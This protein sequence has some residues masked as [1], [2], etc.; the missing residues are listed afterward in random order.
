MEFAVDTD[1]IDVPAL[2]FS[3]TGIILIG[4]GEINAAYKV[5]RREV[6]KLP[7]LYN[8]RRCECSNKIGIGPEF[9]IASLD[10]GD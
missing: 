7:I 9:F 5:F 2:F 3:V 6:F 10:N 4:S 8:L 1:M